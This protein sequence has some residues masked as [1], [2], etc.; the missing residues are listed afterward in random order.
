MTTKQSLKRKLRRALA[1]V[2]RMSLLLATCSL[3]GVSCSQYDLDTRMPSWL[4]QSIYD[5]LKD[6]GN[7]TYTVRMIDDL[8]YAEVLART[9]SKT[10]F[11]ADDAAFDRFFQ[12]NSFGVKSYDALTV[13]Q[14]KMLLYGAMI[15]NSFQINNLSSTEGPVEGDCMRRLSSGTVYDSVPVLKTADMPNNPYWSR[16]REL[17]QVV[18]LEDMSAV[19]MIHFIERHLVNNNITNEDYNF[20]YNNTTRRQSGDASV[21]GVQIA[22]QNIKCS[23]GFV[24]KVQDVMTPL[25]NMA[26]LIRSKS[27]VSE[28]NA[29]LERFCAPYYSQAATENYNRLYNQSVD[30]VFQKRFFSVKSQ[31]GQPVNVSPDNGPVEQLKFDPEWNTYYSGE[32]T[33]SSQSVA[34]EQDMGL[35]MVPSNAAMTDYWN[36]GAGR[37]LKDYYGSWERVPD[38][39]VAELI[40]NNMISSFVSSV[41]SKFGSIMNDANDPMGVKR[42]DVDS[43]WLGCNGAVY[44]TNKVFSPTTYVSVL[45]PAF[46]NQTMN[47]M[48][49][50]VYKCQY[51][52]Y[53]NSLNS[54]YSFFI[55]NNKSLLEYVDPCSYGKSSTQLFR[56]HYDGSKPD[57][58]DRV[59]A[60]IWNYD[61]LTGEVGDSIGCASYE[62]V[63]DRLQDILENHIVV[64]DVTDGHTYYRTM[65]GSEIRVD[66]VAAGKNGMTVSGS[67]QVNEDEGT[68]VNDIY[69][70]QNGRSYV[71][72]NQPIM[73]TRMTVRDILSQHDEYSKF[74][75][76][77][78]GSGL[79]ETIHNGRNACGGTNI[80]VFNTYHYTVY[81]PTNKSLEELI[82][83][84]KLPTWQDV[85]ADEAASNMG[86]KTADSTA[87][88]NFL[89]YHIQDNAIFIGAQAMSGDYETASFDPTNDSFYKLHVNSDANGITVTD[90]RGNKRHVLTSNGKLYNRMAKE[91]QYNSSD[92]AR[93]TQIE[94]SS[95]AV[96]HLIDGP[97]FYAK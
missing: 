13:S 14:K 64:G 88:V 90:A 79:F 62:Q 80:S 70:Q 59:W 11:V 60:S 16:Y 3:G 61:T 89:R 22:E 28:F 97:L 27:Q 42:S 78:D 71:L 31:Q 92:A 77:M 58:N 9:G 83:S 24:H 1:R 66:H 95:S 51:N 12:N 74:L 73:C 57:D 40:N 96:V 25:K 19:P 29:L 35:M 63:V 94:T 75:E 36:H 91:Y 52:V 85:E 2:S 68:A 93:A 41:P 8:G 84:G 10:L 20:I 50:G 46:I 67:W 5:Y 17:G 49:W 32:A 15:N 34:L 48:R 65:G 55:P 44:L 87:I 6:A 23:N 37:V 4:G 82:A 69:D 18:C 39:V 81:V 86:K 21:N 54:T 33:S 76:L 56:F 43:V 38:Y 7:Y 30:S 72:N 53:L 45:F 47:I 26:E